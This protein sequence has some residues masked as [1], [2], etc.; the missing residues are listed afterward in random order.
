MTTP[1]ILMPYNFS[2]ID[3]KAL[4]FV[5]ET[6]A[7]HPDASVTLFHAYT[8]LPDLDVSAN[9]EIRKTMSGMNYLKNELTEKENGLKAICQRLLKS[10]FAEGRVDYIFKKKIKGHADEII[11]V[12]KEGRYGVLVLGRKPGMVSQFFARNIHERLLS[13]LQGVV[14]CIAS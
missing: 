6:Y 9:P 14:V 1:K 11:A 2:M 7:R 5:I 12:A 13:M 10:G 3:E 8:P 4:A